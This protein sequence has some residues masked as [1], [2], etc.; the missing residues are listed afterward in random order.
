VQG[1]TFQYG[2]GTLFRAGDFSFLVT[3]PHVLQ[4]VKA[5]KTLPIPRT[6]DR[7]MKK[8]IDQHG[9]PLPDQALFRIGTTRLQ[10]E[11]QVRALAVSED[12]R[13]LASYQG[14]A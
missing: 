6:A 11:G 14:F 13:F 10:H 3:A 5:D 1:R 4:K 2:T 7:P 8:R 9:D 12:G